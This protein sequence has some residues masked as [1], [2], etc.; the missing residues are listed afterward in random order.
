MSNDRD[1]TPRLIIGL[2][3]L[4]FTVTV[5]ALVV[6]G[7]WDQNTRTLERLVG[8][9]LTAVIVTGVVGALGKSQN[10]RLGK[11]ESQT[12]GKMDERIRENVKAV[13]DE[14]KDEPK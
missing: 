14:R 5:T 8:P 12:N 9:L 6:L 2:A 4:M 13:L 11:I 7:L 1:E 3:A 10:S